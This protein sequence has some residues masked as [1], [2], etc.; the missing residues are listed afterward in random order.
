MKGIY[1]IEC[2]KT[3]RKYVGSSNDINR[4]WI[5]H[6]TELKNGVHHNQFLQRVYN[7]YGFKNLIFV[8]IEVCEELVLTDREI[9]YI[10]K[11][12]SLDRRYGFNFSI[13]QIHPMM[14]TSEEYRKKLSDAKKGKTPSNINLMREKQK[15]AVDLYIDGVFSKTFSSQHEADT[16]LGLTPKSVNNFMI[17]QIKSIKGY[18]DY[19][20]KYSDNKGVRVRKI[21]KI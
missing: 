3:K 8:V 18:R 15:R 5:K 16:Q 10:D 4:R 12:K 11:Y 19:S 14:K 7:K 20:F 13:P 1:Y 21:K 9:Y 6:R 17:G 2:Q